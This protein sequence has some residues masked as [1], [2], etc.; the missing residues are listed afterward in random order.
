MTANLITRIRNKLFGK[1]VSVSPQPSRIC[2]APLFT[3]SV[4]QIL[5]VHQNVKISKNVKKKSH[6]AE[7]E[8]IIDIY[9]KG[10]KKGMIFSFNSENV[11]YSYVPRSGLHK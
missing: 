10:L 6:G 2:S 3:I 7:K 8:L 5:K 9:L 1:T 11:R 4:K